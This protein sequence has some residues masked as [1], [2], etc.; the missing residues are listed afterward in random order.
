MTISSFARSSVRP[1]SF[2]VFSFVAQLLLYCCIGRSLIESGLSCMEATN[3]QEAL[4]AVQSQ[5][6]SLI[7]MDLSVCF[8][9]VLLIENG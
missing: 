7:I 1:F 2:F 6:F 3:G 5:A 9:P 4:T 8:T